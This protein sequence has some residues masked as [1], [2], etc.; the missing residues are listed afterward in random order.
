MPEEKDI[1]DTSYCF[2]GLIGVSITLVVSGLVSVIT[3][4]SHS[5]RYV[6]AHTNK[7][8]EHLRYHDHSVIIVYIWIF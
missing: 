8:C 5:S 3:G 4:N 6:F 1:Y 7:R 2:Y